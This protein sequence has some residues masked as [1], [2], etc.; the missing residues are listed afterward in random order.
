MHK[1]GNT[2]GVV[3]QGY[4]GSAI[5]THF[6]SFFEIITFD[7]YLISKSSENSLKELSEKS[8]IIFVCVPTPM[9]KNGKCDISIVKQVIN[10]INENTKNKIIVIKSTTPP[11]TT[12]TF[13]SIFTNNAI[14]FNP[15]FL[16][17]ANF[18]EDFKNQKKVILGGDAK[19]VDLIAKIYLKAFP[20]IKIIKSDSTEAE[21]VKYFVNCFLA[22][23]V[24]FANEMKYIC[25]GLNLDYNQIMNIAISDNRLGVSHWEVPGPDGDL[26]FGGHCLP[27]DL[28]AILSHFETLGLLEEVKRVN[29]KVRK[30]RDWEK[31]KGRSVAIDFE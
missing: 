18:L 6:K 5:S 20:E 8:D 27:K 4:V 17:E 23:K 25:D 21:M 22:T 9:Q 14:I 2:I 7:K 24:S 19:Y 11:G 16:T 10:E 26:G 12:N 31:M 29:D 28:N 13:K 1:N 30:N 15:E 3:G